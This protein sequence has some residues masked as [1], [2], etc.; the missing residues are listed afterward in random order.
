MAETAE[1]PLA[2]TTEMASV[3]RVFRNALS[4]VPQLVGPAAGDADRAEL[5]G[6]YYDNVLNLLHV[7]HEGEDMLLTP[8]LL[9]RGTAD[10][11]AEIAR[12]AAQ[13]AAVKGDI[14]TAEAR[15]ADFRSSPTV[16]AAAALAGSLATLN[17]SL[18]AH[19]DEEENIAMPIAAKYVNVAEWGQL[20]AHG[21]QHFSGDKLWLVLGL[22]RAEMS[23]AQR[24]NMDAHM[25]PPVFQ[26][27][28]E[29][30]ESLYTDY[31]RALGI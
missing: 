11:T 19:L 9:E 2:D 7:H 13:H 17:A 20:P 8:L 29:T 3:H 16:D 6:S 28:T 24:A 22:L 27:W 10:E 21:L 1:L 26:F 14:E 15:I 4:Q 31:M 12:I 5:V 25:P 30:G 18:V 23:D